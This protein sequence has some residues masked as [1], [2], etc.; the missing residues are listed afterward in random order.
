MQYFLCWL[1]PPLALWNIGKTGQ[2]ILNFLV[3]CTCAGIPFAVLWSVLV[4]QNHLADLRNR[5]LI[6]AVKK[7]RT[8]PPTR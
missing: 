4:T 3:C 1:F 2:A 6:D 5:E 7:Q 8:A